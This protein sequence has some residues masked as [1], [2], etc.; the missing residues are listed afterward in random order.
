M[1]RIDPYRLRKEGP[2]QVQFNEHS[3]EG[4]KDIHYAHPRLKE[5]MEAML[6]KGGDV[7]L[8]LGHDINWYDKFKVMI[9]RVRETWQILN[10]CSILNKEDEI[11]K[12]EIYAPILPYIIGSG[13]FKFLGHIH[14][15]I[16]NPFTKSIIE[17]GDDID[18][19][20]AMID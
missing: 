3:S 11:V 13:R 8:D 9:F 5:E 20:L 6:K 7:G 12:A 15:V 2:R 10:F 19:Y 18:A 1:L 14:V 4:L 17:L 16:L